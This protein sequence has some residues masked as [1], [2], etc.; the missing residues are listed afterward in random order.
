MIPESIIT[1]EGPLSNI[2]L[3]ANYDK[4]LTKHQLLN[5]NIVQSTKYINNRY[6]NQESSNIEL[7]AVTLR[8][9]GQLLLGIT[10]IYSRKTKYLLD[11]LND[12]LYKLRTVFKSSSGVQLG[13][14]GLTTTKVNLPPQQ[15]TIQDI[16]SI[17]LKDQVT[18]FDLLWQDDLNLEETVQP[19]INTLDTVFNT[20]DQQVDASMGSIEYGRYDEEFT[21]SS[22]QPNMNMD[23]DL[24]DMDDDFGNNDYDASIE[25]GRNVSMN[26]DNDDNNSLLGELSKNDIF[27]EGAEFGDGFDLN[28]DDNDVLDNETNEHEV[29]EASEQSQEPQEST[30]PQGPTRPTRPRQ[31]R[32]R[33]TDDGEMII[34][35]K[36][37]IVDSEDSM[38]ISIDTLRENQEN[39]MNRNINNHT[40]PNNRPIHPPLTNEEKLKIIEDLANQVFKKRKLNDLSTEYRLQK[41][42]E[43]EEE[44]EIDTSSDSM[45]LDL[46]MSDSESENDA[47]L[48]PRKSLDEESGDEEEDDSFGDDRIDNIAKSTRQIAEEVQNLFRLDHSIT[49][50]DILEEDTKAVKPLGLKNKTIN[51]RREASRCFFEVLVLATN[52]CVKLQQDEKTIRISSRDNLYDFI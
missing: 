27:S 15:T 51:T 47:P 37:L 19:T 45:D 24:N 8:L 46:S 13:S 4:K 28:F 14:D 5:T 34:V 39:M 49:F 43:E 9:S 52:D 16:N 6:N 33:I 20:T 25:M 30:E 40:T 21:T 26:A 17:L 3:A 38:T 32:T 18:G 1:K 48:K 31:R 10:K 11:D 44:S 23:F 29:N 36:R 7:D 35:N 12:V 2:W 50:N 42:R 22:P 41:Q